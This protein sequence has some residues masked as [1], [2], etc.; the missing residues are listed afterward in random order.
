MQE[1]NVDVRMRGQF[2]PPVSAESYDREL[3]CREMFA[4]IGAEFFLYR[5][6]GDPLDQKIGDQTPRLNDLL[7]ADSETVP[8]AQS[9]CLYLQ[10]FFERDES[11]R[12]I[13]LILDLP[14]FLARM[15][16]YCDQ[17]NLHLV[18]AA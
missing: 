1:H 7:S 14:K 5:R 6:S 18:C 11:L 13:R 2:P 17:I 9:L 16:L 8:Q 4:E 10:E 15:T 12:R 3:T